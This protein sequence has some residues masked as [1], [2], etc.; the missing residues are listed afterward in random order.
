MDRDVLGARDV[1]GYILLVVS[2][3]DHERGGASPAGG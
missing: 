1:P 2:Y 3:V